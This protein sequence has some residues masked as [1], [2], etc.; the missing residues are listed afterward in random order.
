M[1]H[2][3]EQATEHQS[4]HKNRNTAAVPPPL[5][6]EG[7]EVGSL[8]RKAQ[9]AQKN[10]AIYSPPLGEDGRGLFPLGE[11]LGEA[12]EELGVMAVTLFQEVEGYA[13]ENSRH[14]FLP[15][16]REIPSPAC[17]PFRHSTLCKPILHVVS[18]FP[19]R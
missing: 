17:H 7:L 5:E 8:T 11:D 16:H 1:S 4:F 15:L 6:G 13:P 14:Y 9:K 2:S 10:Y 12:V 3:L 18:P 19:P